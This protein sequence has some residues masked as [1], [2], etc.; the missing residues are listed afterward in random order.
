MDSR[1]TGPIERSDRMNSRRAGKMNL[2]RNASMMAMGALLLLAGC[3]GS[4]PPV[5][6]VAGGD[7]GISGTITALQQ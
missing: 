7:S 2:G 3:G 1:G 6:T 4:D 5:V